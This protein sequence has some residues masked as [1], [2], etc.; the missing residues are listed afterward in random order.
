MP[1]FFIQR[2]DILD[3]HAVLIGEDAR[4]ISRS[5][6]MA[7]GDSLTLSDGEG[8]EL[9][10]RLS[11]FTD[12]SVTAEI[13]SERESPNESP[14]RIH[15]YQG[16]PKGDKL[17][18][19][20]EKAV[21]LGAA[22]VTPFLSSFVVKRPP[23]DKEE[24]LCARHNKI[25]LSAAQQCGRARLPRVFPTL[26]FDAMLKEACE[27]GP[28]LFC[29]EGIGTYALPFVLEKLPPHITSLSVIVGSEGGFS[30]AEA[31]KA[32]QAGCLLTGLGKRILRS[33]TAPLFVLSALSYA[34]ELS[35]P[36]KKL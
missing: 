27:R 4:H 21:E 10:C 33:E 16:Y 11:G 19:V 35:L 31:K 25:A 8:R 20:I 32:E 26:S 36:C 29:Y 28:A 6:R 23:A 13:L 22:T 17:E 24:K 12:D 2:S 9:F 5:L 34:F 30:E 1:R 3:G 15:L 7:V 18:T 14:L